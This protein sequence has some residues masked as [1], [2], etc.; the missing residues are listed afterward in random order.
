MAKENRPA[1]PLTCLPGVSLSC[2]MIPDPLS[3]RTVALRGSHGPLWKSIGPMQS[4]AWNPASHSEER[5]D[6]MS[7]QSHE[8]QG[9][10]AVPDED[11][12]RREFLQEAAGGVA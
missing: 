2:E 4:A 7:K 10:L 5:L 11:V 8:V 1:S 9:S 3:N 6:P 12:S